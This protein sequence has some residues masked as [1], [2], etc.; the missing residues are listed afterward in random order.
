[1]ILLAITKVL[2]S[3]KM[4]S[5]TLF[6]VSTPFNGYI[7][8]IA[9]GENLILRGQGINV[10]GTG[11]R[12][13]L[14]L[15]DSSFDPPTGPTGPTGPIDTNTI[16]APGAPGPVGPPGPRGDVIVSDGPTGPTGPRGNDGAPYDPSFAAGPPG[17]TGITGP[18]GRD[19]PSGPTGI[20]GPR[21]AQGPTGGPGPVGIPGL[22]SNTPGPTGDKGPVGATGIYGT[23]Y[24]RVTASIDQTGGRSRL[25]YNGQNVTTIDVILATYTNTFLG[26]GDGQGYFCTMRILGRGDSFYTIQPGTDYMAINLNQNQS[27]CR[28]TTFCPFSDTYYGWCSLEGNQIIFG[29]AAGK[30]VSTPLQF[31]RDDIILTSY[32]NFI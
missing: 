26:N 8:N 19:G 17:V 10:L 32:G 27:I 28:F 1:M 31:G 21:G 7:G 18:I 6:S 29:D 3:D 12:V 2:R 13:Y 11:N 23:F 9:P 15:Q 5:G 24:Q 22:A 16:A 4:S 14:S 25:T 30:I 20:Q